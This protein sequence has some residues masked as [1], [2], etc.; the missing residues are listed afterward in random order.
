MVKIS[1]QV[2]PTFNLQ[3]PPLR[4]GK[5]RKKITGKMGGKI[6]EKNGEK[7]RE[8]FREIGIKMEGKNGKKLGESVCG[9]ELG[10]L[11]GN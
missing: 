8:I 5:W 4:V 2:S 7:I 3:P 1:H 11:G 10:K 9:G 6:E